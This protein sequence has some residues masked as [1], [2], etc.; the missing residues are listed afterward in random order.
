[1]I[2][3]PCCG[4]DAF[5]ARSLFSSFSKYHVTHIALERRKQAISGQHSASGISLLIAQSCSLSTI[6]LPLAYPLTLAPCPYFPGNSYGSL[7]PPSFECFVTVYV[8]TFTFIL[9]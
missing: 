5:D 3:P 7:P 6:H 2:N 1:M 8:I 4:F 9:L